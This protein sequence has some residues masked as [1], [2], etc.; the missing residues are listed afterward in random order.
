MSDDYDLGKDHISVKT[1]TVV[2][3]KEYFI[4][5]T[6]EGPIDI[7]VEIKSDFQ[8]IPEKYHE[9]CLNVLTSKYLNKVDFNNNSFSE[10][11]FVKKRKWYQFWKSQ[12]F[13]QK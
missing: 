9:I 10:C 11:K 13:Q 8:N 3:L 12:Y 1:S 6:L 7:I 2:A 5:N 4:V